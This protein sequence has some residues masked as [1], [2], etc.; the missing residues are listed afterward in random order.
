[1]TQTI[2]AFIAITL[3]PAVKNELAQI[4]SLLAGQFPDRSVRWVQPDKMHLTL[5][6]LGDTAVNQLL[7]ITQQLDELTA[8]QPA[9][10][11]QLN[12][13][14][15]FPNRKRPRVIWVGVAG[16]TATLQLVKHDLDKRLLP[17]GWTQ[18]NKPFRAHLT[19]GRVKDG[20]AAARVNWQ[21][22]VNPIT[23]PVNALHLIESQLTSQGPIYTTQHTTVF[24]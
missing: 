24:Q 22:T 16:E 12:G 5:R 13:L 18:E 10:R 11:L 4:R 14:G 9:F 1:M 6:F 20:R 19:L 3:P 23:F 2:R 15:C 8:E 17:L 21:A 7:S